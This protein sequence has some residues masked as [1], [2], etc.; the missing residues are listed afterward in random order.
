M[1]MPV[2]MPLQPSRLD[3][4]SLS[5]IKLARPASEAQTDFTFC[6]ITATGSLRLDPGS[7]AAFDLWQQG[8]TTAIS[9]PSPHRSPTR[10]EP[11]A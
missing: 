11:G 4:S 3:L 2:P 5:A 1:R 9:A 7:K 6:I 8:L 10:A